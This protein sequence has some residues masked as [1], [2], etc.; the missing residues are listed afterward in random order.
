MLVGMTPNSTPSSF[1]RRG[2]RPATAG[3]ERCSPGS[4][5]RRRV[6]A[7]A[8]RIAAAAALVALAGGAVS[9]CRAV[10]FLNGVGQEHLDLARMES[11]I[12]SGLQRRLE[13]DSRST[14][15]SVTSVGRVRCRERSR[16]AATCRARVAR[17][18]GRQVVRIEV[19]VDPDTG[20]YTWELVD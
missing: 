16:L 19:T 17:P 9:D 10:D 11:D 1:E 14:S 15:S 2:A 4:V 5:G 7:R 20:A 6:P 12:R 13:E 18:S 8:R 3:G